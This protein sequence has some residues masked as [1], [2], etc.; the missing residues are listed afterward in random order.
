MFPCAYSNESLVGKNLDAILTIQRRMNVNENDLALMDC[1][2]MQELEKKMK[3][4]NIIQNNQQQQKDTPPC[5][6]TTTPA[7]LSPPLG[8]KNL[9]SCL[10]PLPPYFPPTSLPYS[11]S[12]FLF[13]DPDVRFGPQY[14]PQYYN[15]QPSAP[16][17]FPAVST[18]Q[19]IQCKN[20]ETL[21]DLLMKKGP[22]DLLDVKYSVV[23][24]PCGEPLTPLGYTP[25]G[26][27]QSFEEF[28]IE[29]EEFL[30]QSLSVEVDHSKHTGWTK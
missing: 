12:P 15:M 9:E 14:Y 19:S 10:P 22:N 26:G 1:K 27:G 23:Q 13:P 5:Q 17:S 28:F 30:S 6:N 24:M 4:A 18:G 11:V 21:T 2:H 16:L 20:M 8:D 3:S 29:N 7:P 25:T